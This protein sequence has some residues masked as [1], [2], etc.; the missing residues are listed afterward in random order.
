MKKRLYA[1]GFTLA[2]ILITLVIVG[3]IGALGVPMLG[4][5]KL[6]KPEVPKS[7][8]GVFECY[9]DAERNLHQFTSDNSSRDTM[10]GRDTIVNGQCSFTPPIANFYTIQVIGA[11]GNG[12]MYES[13]ALPDYS[14]TLIDGDEGSVS[15]G[16]AFASDLASAPDWVRERWDSQ[17]T[18]GGGAAIP[19]YTVRSPLGGSGD[20]VCVYYLKPGK[21]CEENCSS[22]TTEC[23]N[24]HSSCVGT[25]IGRGGNG[26]DGASYTVAVMLKSNYSVNISED[27]S[28]TRLDFGPG[29]YIELRGSGSGTDA[30]KSSDHVVISGRDGASFNSSSLSS[31]GLTLSE[32]A[33]IS[34]QSSP[35]SCNSSGASSRKGSVSIGIV[36]SIKYESQDLAVRALFGYKGEP[37]NVVSRVVTKLPEVALHLRPARTSAE[38]SIVSIYTESSGNYQDFIVA[39]PG[40]AGEEHLAGTEDIRLS[41]SAGSDF[42]FPSAYYSSAF[43]PVSAG[44]PRF[45][46]SGYATKFPELLANPQ[47]APGR[48]GMGAYPVLVTGSANAY[49]RINNVSVNPNPTTFN[50]SANLAS[51]SCLSGQVPKIA[52]NG[53][54]Y[55]EA[56]KGNPGAIAIIW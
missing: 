39:E 54:Y 10:V 6:N 40:E 31:S 50:Y 56:T 23:K 44:I 33:T 30:Y 7:N 26:G 11:G 12:G 29:G 3:F 46:A 47:V 52:P 17:W 2:E 34:G 8:H 27:Y 14:V 53:K 45:S 4:Q 48:S 19:R 18:A 41:L 5:Q 15:T 42:P 32:K 28:S 43:S 35:S 13:A 38:N 24:E 49:Y 37:G 55:C 51:Y 20:T 1:Q 21:E 9:Y 22:L 36:S 25:S 16:T